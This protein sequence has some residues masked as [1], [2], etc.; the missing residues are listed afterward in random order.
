MSLERRQR[1]A[2]ARTDQGVEDPPGQV[3]GADGEDGA[4]GEA[5]GAGDLV[6]VGRGGEARGHGRRGCVGGGWGEEGGAEEEGGGGV[7]HGVGWLGSGR[8]VCG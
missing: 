1:R 5:E 8:C 4:A 2:E 6:A 3:P 7:G